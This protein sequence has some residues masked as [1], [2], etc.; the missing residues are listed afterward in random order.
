MVA[1]PSPA[2]FCRSV[3]RAYCEAVHASGQ[4]RNLHELYSHGFDPVLKSD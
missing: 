4:D 3:A 1:H 2:S